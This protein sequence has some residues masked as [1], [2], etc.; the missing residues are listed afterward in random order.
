[1]LKE[2]LT[3]LPVV[4]EDEIF[5]GLITMKDLSRNMLNEKGNKLETS[6]QNILEVLNGEEVLKFD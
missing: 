1:M 3:G 5:S 2:N 6:Y 4:K